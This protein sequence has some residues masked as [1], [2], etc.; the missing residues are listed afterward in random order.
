[1]GANLSPRFDTFGHA[2]PITFEIRLNLFERQLG[3]H[4]WCNGPL[5]LSQVLFRLRRQF[6]SSNVGTERH[7]LPNRGNGHLGHLPLWLK[8]IA[9][10][11][12]SLKL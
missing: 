6:L 11:P 8:E 2:L 7:L 5:V 4:L 3:L 12:K 9:I 1:M 10:R